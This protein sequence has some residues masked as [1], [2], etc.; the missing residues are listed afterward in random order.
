MRQAVSAMLCNDFR[1]EAR[2]T[3]PV[4]KVALPVDPWHPRDDDRKPWGADEQRERKRSF[5]DRP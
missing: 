4:A 3:A 1:I 5:A 2:P